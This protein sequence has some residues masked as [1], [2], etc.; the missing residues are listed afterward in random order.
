MTWFSVCTVGAGSSLATAASPLAAPTVAFQV[1]N[2]FA[3][4]FGAPC[5]RR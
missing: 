4:A 1:R 5:S 3:V 2:V